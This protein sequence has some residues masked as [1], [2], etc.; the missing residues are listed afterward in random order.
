MGAWNF[1]DRRIEQVLTG[2]G[3]WR[4]AAALCRP[5]RGGKPGDRIGPRACGG[6]GGA[7]R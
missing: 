1:V 2:I 4:Q 5:R 7:G 3:R 6:A